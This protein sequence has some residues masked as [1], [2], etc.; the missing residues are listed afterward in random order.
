[1]FKR[2]EQGLKQAYEDV[3]HHYYD[4]KTETLY[5]SGTNPLDY[6]DIYADVNIPFGTLSTTDRYKQ[7]VQLID[8]YNPKQLVGHSLGASEV[9]EYQKYNPQIKT[10]TYAA[11]VV[12]LFGGTASD[13][14]KH[15]W[16][17]V[18]LFDRNAISTTSKSWNPHT[19]SG[20][21]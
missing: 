7:M 13:R 10:R 9:L 1:M 12:S 21:Y 3:N 8:L 17:P 16:D 18:A 15:G 5:I 4:D 20:Y 11:P 19:F 6:K 2:D 14:Y